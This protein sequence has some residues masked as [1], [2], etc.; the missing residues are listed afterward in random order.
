MPENIWQGAFLTNRGLY[1]PI[2][3]LF[4]I[5]NALVS[6]QAITNQIFCD[7][8]DQGWLTVYMDDITVY[9]HTGESL[10]SH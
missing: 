6:F 8:I 5:C 10:E 2:V 3:M 4:S 1:E 7:F 9:T